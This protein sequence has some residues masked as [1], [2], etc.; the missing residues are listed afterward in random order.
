MCTL[1]DLKV[2]YSVSCPAQEGQP[3]YHR[4][5]WQGLA[6]AGDKLAV[7]WFFSK[8]AAEIV[9][10]VYSATDGRCLGHQAVAHERRWFSTL[11]LAWSETGSQ[12][13]VRDSSS[14]RN[15]SSVGDEANTAALVLHS[16]AASIWRLADG[17]CQLTPS[18]CGV[19]WATWRVSSQLLKI[20]F[21][22][23]ATGALV[24]SMQ[25]KLMGSQSQ[26][27]QY[28]NAG[29]RG[30]GGG[31]GERRLD[32][33]LS[34]SSPR[35]VNECAGSQQV[36]FRTLLSVLRVGELCGRESAEA[37]HSRLSRHKFS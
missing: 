5:H 17:F 35:P 6:P 33:A 4:V 30:G 8:R 26:R 13:V 2:R 28:A 1:P 37:G 16:N 32:P 34:E 29:R 19:Q 11:Q 3:R 7:A 22:D 10:A 18:P 9:I 12:I 31:R 25:V 15:F 14:L 23:L 36:E 24:S 20:E 21:Y 27:S